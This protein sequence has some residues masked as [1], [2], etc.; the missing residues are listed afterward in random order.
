MKD[1]I[2]TYSKKHGYLH[3][4]F[5][6]RIILIIFYGNDRLS[7]DAKFFCKI[8]LLYYSDLQKSKSIYYCVSINNMACYTKV[9]NANC[10]IIISEQERKFVD[11]NKGLLICGE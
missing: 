5:Q 4:Q 10:G 6:R 9:E 8:T 3:G 2:Y 1:I 11:H 7:R